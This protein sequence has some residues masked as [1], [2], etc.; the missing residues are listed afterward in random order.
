MYNLGV[1]QTDFATRTDHGT[2]TYHG[3]ETYIG[4]RTMHHGSNNITATN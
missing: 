4:D 1:D 2:H 3:G